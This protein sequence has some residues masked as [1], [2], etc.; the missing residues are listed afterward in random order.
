MSRNLTILIA[1]VVVIGAIV[2]FGRS[3]REEDSPPS[4]APA[5]VSESDRPS[6]SQPTAAKPSG[7]STSGERR[8]PGATSA[9][10]R[11]AELE[12]TYGRAPLLDPELEAA[13]RNPPD[14]V[15]PENWDEILANPPELPPEVQKVLDDPPDVTHAPEV[16][17]IFREEPEV[18]IP[19]HV[20]E[21]IDNPE[22]APAPFAP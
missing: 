5:I 1:V 14:P 7:D 13:L 4:G 15:L 10:A 2:L 21:L 6:D 18:E 17:Q 8:E 19:R 12:A 22:S 9:D 11:L 3:D 16:E 20:Q